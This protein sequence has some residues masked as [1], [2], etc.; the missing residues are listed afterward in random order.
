[1][2]KLTIIQYFSCPGELLFSV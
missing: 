1:L 2:Q